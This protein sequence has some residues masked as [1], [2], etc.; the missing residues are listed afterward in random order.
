M[1][2]ESNRI[3]DPC[4]THRD[5]DPAVI[6]VRWML[7]IETTVLCLCPDPIDGG[8][9]ESVFVGWILTSTRS[10]PA[11]SK[12]RATDDPHFP[13]VTLTEESRQSSLTKVVELKYRHHAEPL[14]G[15]VDPS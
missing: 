10:G 7:G 13:T 5:A 8:P 11:G 6:L 9:R 4:R 3:V 12:R 14:P 1:L 15:K 2:N